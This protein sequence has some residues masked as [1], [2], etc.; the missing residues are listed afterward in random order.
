MLLFGVFVHLNNPITSEVGHET[1]KNKI[2]CIANSGHE[3][4]REFEKVL[5]CVSQRIHDYDK[6]VAK[7][8]IFRTPIPIKRVY[9]FF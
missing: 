2:G 4:E 7:I 8:I 9:Q 3:F 1:N 6:F 5:K